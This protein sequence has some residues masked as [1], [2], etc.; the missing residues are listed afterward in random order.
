MDEVV[1]VLFVI[2]DCYLEEKQFRSADHY[3]LYF[4]PVKRYNGIIIS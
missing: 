3:P 2:V 4:V 1:A